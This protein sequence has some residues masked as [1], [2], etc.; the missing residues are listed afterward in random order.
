MLSE[1]YLFCKIIIMTF[2]LLK[3]LDVCVQ[4]CNLCAYFYINSKNILICCR[5]IIMPVEQYTRYHAI[6]LLDTAIKNNYISIHFN[7]LFLGTVT[8]GTVVLNISCPSLNFSPTHLAW[9]LLMKKPH[10]LNICKS[11]W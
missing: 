10:T 8:C 7:A 11:L 3:L 4:N 2:N 5:K 6:Y 1:A 9:L